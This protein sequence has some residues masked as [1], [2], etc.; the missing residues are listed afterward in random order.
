AA[1]AIDGWIVLGS[2]VGERLLQAVKVAE[3]EPLASVLLGVFLLTL[4]SATPLCIGFLFTLVAGSWG[5]GAV[6]LTRFGT[7]PYPPFVATPE[8]A[9]SLPVAEEAPKEEEE[10]P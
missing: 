8:E 2:V 3:P 4:I 7:T 1:A 9:P 5:L 6:I 10:T